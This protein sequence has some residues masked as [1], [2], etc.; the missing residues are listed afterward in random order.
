MPTSPST[1]DGTGRGDNPGGTIGS[2]SYARNLNDLLPYNKTLGDNPGVTFIFGP[3]SPKG[4]TFTTMHPR[5]TKED[6]D[7]KGFVFRGGIGR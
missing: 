6:G 7:P 4:Y 1:Q 5:G 2:G 3:T